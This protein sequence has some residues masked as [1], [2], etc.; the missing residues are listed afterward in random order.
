[1]NPDMWSNKVSQSNIEKLDQAEIKIIGP[2][3]GTHAC[4]DIGYGR[5]TNPEQ[6]IEDIKSDSDTSNLSGSRI[7]VTAGPTREPIDPV[8]FMS[9]Y[10]SGKMGY[11][12]ALAARTMGA[13]VKIISGPVSLDPIKNIET[14]YVETSKEM[15]DAV[16]SNVKDFDIFI[17]TAAIADY[18]PT[19]YSKTKYK[20]NENNISIE[21]TR[22]IDIIKSVSKEYDIYT[23]GFAAE[24]DSLYKNSQEKLTRK[25]L[26]MIIGNIANHE[27]KL[28]FESDFK[29]V[30]IFYKDKILKIPE[31]KKSEIAK[32]V[33]DVIADEYSYKMKLVNKDVK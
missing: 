13:H 5:M 9:N 4:G 6:I 21:F 28:G 22:G 24:T 10:S 30:T 11:E 8:R 33:L 18:K 25:G 12:I 23:V 16:M 31:A 20:K 29:K 17:S 2:N 15:F 32:S 26:D 27:L 14:Q 7:L 19:D 1:M 3:Y